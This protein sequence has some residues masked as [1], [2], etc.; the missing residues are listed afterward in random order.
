MGTLVLNQI[1]V[2]NLAKIHTVG[3]DILHALKQGDIGFKSFGEAYFSWIHA[4]HVK[5]WK[6]HRSQT[7][8]LV[9]PIGQVKFVFCDQSSNTFKVL[10]IGDDNYCRITVPR[11]IWFGFKG[12]SP[13]ASLIM[14]I[15]SEV[16]DPEEVER[17][18]ESEIKFDW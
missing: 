4:G 3:G 8:N 15:S 16:H 17:K 10:E 13:Q 6:M 5:A 2:T 11:G 9:V 1:Q 14:N 12:I 18:E 7:M